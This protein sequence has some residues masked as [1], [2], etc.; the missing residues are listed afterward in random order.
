MFDSTNSTAPGSCKVSQTALM[1]IDFHCRFVDKAGGPQAPAAL[2][3]ASQ[4]RSWAKSQRIQVIHCLLDLAASPYPTFKGVQRYAEVIKSMESAD[5]GGEEHV[6]L[7]D[8]IGDDVVFTRR[9]GYGSVFYSPGLSSFLQN[10]GIK[11]LLIAGLP[12]S[13]SVARTAF[14]ACDA[15]YIVTIISDGCADPQENLHTAFMEQALIARGWVA[16]SAEFQEGIVN[17][18]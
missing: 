7:V 4:L 13:G 12:T 15:E 9:P 18:H 6:M 17:V 1:L 11:S 10:K 8:N 16:T 5:G 14:A 2:R 3:V